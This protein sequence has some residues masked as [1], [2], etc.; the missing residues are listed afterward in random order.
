M[1]WWCISVEWASCQIRKIAGCACAGNAGNVFSATDIFQRKLIVGDPGMHHGTCV[2]HVSWCMSGSLT[3]YDGENDPGI[4]GA[5]ETRSFTYLARGPLVLIASGN[6]LS[7]AR[8][9]AIARTNTDLLSIKPWGMNFG[10]IGVKYE[11]FRSRKC[12]RGRR[13]NG[14]H[15][16]SVAICLLMMVSW[17]HMAI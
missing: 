3:R 16:F 5:C 12:K 17:G 15:F 7:P 4:P 2:T 14:A 13:Q 8:R 1:A 10:E 11:N 6:G 9:Q